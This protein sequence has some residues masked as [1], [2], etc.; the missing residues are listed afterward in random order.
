MCAAIAASGAEP[1]I[2]AVVDGAP[3]VGVTAPELERLLSREGVRKISARDL[4]PAVADRAMGATTVAGAL[5]LIARTGVTVFATGGIGGVHRE[6]AYDE[7]SDLVELSRTPRVV[8][9]SGAKAILDLGA[10]VERLESLGVPVIGYRTRE[11]PAFFSSSSGLDVSA[12]CDT[13]FDVARMVTAHWAFGRNESVLVVQPP[14]ADHALPTDLVERAVGDALAQARDRGIRGAGIT[15]FLLAAVERATN[16][17]SLRTNL[18]LLE[19]NASLAA[20]I[21]AC[22]TSRSGA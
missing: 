18:A 4:G 7:S 12:T 16:G 1:A 15:P 8:V 21:A 17:R 19:A 14:P 20:G 5:A 11:F 22:L 9:C 10:T 6:P 3:S 13:A 2:T